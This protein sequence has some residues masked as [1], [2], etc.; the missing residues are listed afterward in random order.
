MKAKRIL[1]MIMSVA[2]IITS[3]GL[4][5]ETQAANVTD[6]PIVITE[7]A[8]GLVTVG[9]A[10]GSDVTG[11]NVTDGDA[12]D[13]DVTGGDVTDGDV[14]DGDVTGGDVTDGDVTDGDATDGDVS[15]GDIIVELDSEY[16]NVDG[17]GVLILKEGVELAD[18]KG[19]I[20]LPKEAVV[21]PVGIFSKNTKVTGLTVPEES[22]LEKID[23]GAFEGSAIKSMTIPDAVTVIEAETFKDS[24]LQ[25]IRFSDNSG[26]ELI[27]EEAFAGS[28]LVSIDIPAQVATV[29]DAAFRGCLE[30]QSVALVNV[31]SL[32]VNAFKGCTLLNVVAWGKQLTTVGDGAFSATGL[33]KIELNNVSGAGIENW[34]TNVF[35]KCEYL[36]RVVLHEDMSV[37]PEGMFKDCTSLTYI[38]LP[39]N[40]T[41]IQEAAFSGCS[42]VSKITIPAKVGMIHAK[43]FAG[44]Q[45]LDEVTIKQRGDNELREADIVIAETAFPEKTMTMKGYDGT[46]E[47]YADRKGYTFVTLY[48]TNSIAV[49]V[50]NEEYGTATV[51]KKSAR[52]GEVI[53]VTVTPATDYRLK[54]STFGYNGNPIDNLVEMTETD[55]VFSFVMPDEDVTVQVD[56]EKNTVSYGK[57]SASFVQTNPDMIYVWDSTNKVLTLDKVGLSAKLV[58]KSSKGASY[59][60]GAWLFDYSS[61]DSKIAV[62][63]STGV[64]YARGVGTTTIT[65][66]MKDNTDTKVSFKVKVTEEAGISNVE[67]LYSDL[68]KA[69]LTVDEI[70]GKEYSV[71]QYTKSNL[72]KSEK[73]FTVKLC[74]TAGDD[75]TS[76]FVNAE[77]KTA[78][79][80]IAYPE[81][82]TTSD[83]KNVIHVKK[84]VT[85]ET[86][87]TVTVTNG[88]TGKKKVVLY[89]ESF[90]IRVMDVTPRLLQNTISLN[91]LCTTGTQFDLLSVYGYEVETSGL[92]VV[93]AVKEGTITEYEETPYATVSYKNGEFYMQLT[94]EGKDAVIKKG[95]DITYKNMYIQ[96][97]YT[98]DTEYGSATEVFRTAIKNLVLTQKAPKPTV[99]LSGSLNLFFNGQADVKDRGEVTIK[100]TVKNIT[101]AVVAKYELVSEANYNKAGS[102]AVDSF[103][104]NFVVS[105][106]GVISRSS[107]ALIKNS[108]GK[109]VTSGYLKITYEGYEPCYVKINVPVK[110][111]KPS[112]ALS[113]TKA[114]VNS[115]SNGYELELQLLDKKTKKAISL[116]N[117]AE[118]SFDE[119]ASGT[120]TGLFEDMD[121]EAARES[122]VITLQIQK[123][124]KGKAVINVEMD[125]W[126]EPLKFTFN[127]NVTTKAPT[128]K[129]KPTTLTLNNLCVGREAQTVLT[130]NQ[131]DVELT[132]MGEAVFAGKASLADEA[133]KI[134][135]AYEDGVLSAVATDSVKK[136][137]YKFRF[138]PQVTYTNGKTETIKAINITVKVVE[139]KLTASLKPATVSLNNLYAGRETVSTAYTIK[140]LPVNENIAIL[141]DDVVITGTN[142]KAE[143]VKS[144]FEF[145]FG[146][147]D[148][149]IQVTQNEAVRSTGT[150]KY[151]ISGLKV[152]VAGTPVEV[153]PFT[154]G[155]KVIKTA[156][157]LTVK[158]S[159]SLNPNNSISSIVY[160]FTTKNVS[161]KIVDLEVKELNTTNGLNKPYDT[162]TN[163]KVGEIALDDNGSI[164]SVEILAKDN[165]V[166]DAKKTYKLRFGA[167][168]EGGTSA[169][170]WTGDIKITPKQA[171]PKI[172]TDVTE[173]TLYAGVAMNDPKR[174]QEVQ[175]IKTTEQSAE[176]A[177]VKLA[178]GT[179]DNLQKALRVTF[180][181]ETQ[182]AKITLLR[183]DLLKPNTTYTVRFEV[184][185]IGQMANTT[186][187]Q[188]TMKIKIQN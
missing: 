125:T 67:L 54:A 49:D 133:S 74:P 166:L 131:A 27:E 3:S 163:F 38:A 120:T 46:V 183:P 154:L 156:P 113:K 184:R 149:T 98:Y 121:T 56:F 140:N 129:A 83:N 162:L 10:D 136:G 137:N 39:A 6:M 96:G 18:L 151:K 52:Q 176:I 157:K 107:N 106:D 97:E 169:D 89:E 14:T 111:T 172:K 36:N 4:S 178:K 62:I 15:K 24:K 58:V 180:D 173:A 48:P 103:A 44:C 134:V 82:A 23:A 43:A 124:Q 112:Y 37:I 42:A 63:D 86:A 171:L 40:C 66:T 84:G 41:T 102:E 132:D 117:L 186:G 105:K 47:D 35:E 65:A 30:L 17:N 150:Y 51:S 64:I 99:K 159:G 88:Q 130:L 164:K 2:M 126:N 115:F 123:A 25:T 109:V 138:T 95:R 144:A 53:Q 177:S 188:F 122:D 85:G 5:L 1:A 119:S 8:D 167:V 174:S 148:T 152:D 127:L 168:L 76:L 141:S 71:V 104:N 22:L 139:S 57:L 93:Q 79:E 100:Q 181:P 145:V 19:T 45:E 26:L 101:N 153:Q 175:I 72:Q 143:D 28:N 13:G 77:W 29:E 31:E 114:T 69:K 32:G 90:I 187:P 55:L 78:N 116:A 7:S 20:E 34:G 12:T 161:A 16:F 155:V 182:K 118:L 61:K 59:N 33:Q 110:T 185:M 128:L 80:D 81:L 165:V 9:S 142:G 158:A 75:S 179:S 94:Q 108:K 60:P 91:A 73:A 68:G 135:F 146:A 92:A 87:I 21:I 160:T 147:D 70:D 11:G 170:V 50:N